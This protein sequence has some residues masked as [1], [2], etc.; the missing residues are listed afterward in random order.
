MSQRRLARILAPADAEIAHRKDAMASGLM[1]GRTCS[2]ST[3][4]FWQGQAGKEDCQGI[5]RCGL[6]GKP[7]RASHDAADAF[8]NPDDQMEPRSDK[9]SHHEPHRLAGI[10][11]SFTPVIE[12]SIGSGDPSL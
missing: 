8:V 9:R 2:D 3:R 6:A 11:V 4:Q 10:D 12:Q 1:A 7:P 5:L